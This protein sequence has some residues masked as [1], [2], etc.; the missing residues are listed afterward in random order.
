LIASWEWFI[1]EYQLKIEA[2]QFKIEGKQC[3]FLQIGSW[4]EKCHPS[5]KPADI[6]MMALRSGSYPVL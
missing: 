3:L 2:T 6:W 5:M 1:G 4:N